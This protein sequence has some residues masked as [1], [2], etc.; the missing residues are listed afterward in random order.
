MHILTDPYTDPFGKT[1]S[2]SYY[3]GGNLKE[4]TYPGNNTVTYDYDARNLLTSVSFWGGRTINYEYTNAGRLKKITY[5][6]GA[7]IDYGYD[8]YYRLKTVSNRKADGSII[9]EY[10]IDSFDAFD[11][12]LQVSIT[13]GIPATSLVLSESY[14]YDLNNRIATAGTASFSHSNLG[15][16]ETK[17]KDGSTTTFTWDANEAGGKLQSIS[18]DGSVTTYEYDGLGN[19]IAKTE[20]GVTTR[21]ILDVSGQMANILAETDAN[22]NVTTYYIHGLGLVAKILPDGTASYYHYDRIGNTVALTDDS[23][24]VTDQYAYDPDP[25]GFGVTKQGETVNPFTFIG[26]YGVMDEGNNIYYMR[27]RYYNAEAGRFLSEDPIGFEGGDLNLYAYVGGN[28]MVGIDP[29]GLEKWIYEKEISPRASARALRTIFEYGNYCGPGLTGG[30]DKEQGPINTTDEACKFHDLGEDPENNPI[31][32]DYW[33]PEADKRDKSLVTR[34]FL[35]IHQEDPSEN[36]GKAMYRS[37]GMTFFGLK[38]GTYK[39]VETMKWY[40]KNSSW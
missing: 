39:S 23:G 25:Y 36:L 21:Y 33:S 16:I 12:P 5:P 4:I 30:V 35:S 7:Y 9:A 10:T 38:I 13:G 31:A 37:A 28:P 8:I 20:D 17:T 22:G 27:A 3:P 26:R 14:S 40:W 6:N 18:Q 32:Y 24:N 11:A 1:V 29:V 15:E 2:Y 19:R 34:W